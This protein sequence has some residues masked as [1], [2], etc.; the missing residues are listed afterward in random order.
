MSKTFYYFVWGGHGLDHIIKEIENDNSYTDLIIFGPEEHEP[1]MLFSDAE[2][3]MFKRFLTYHNVNLKM[4]L[5]AP[6]NYVLNNR[7]RFKNYKE[8]HSWHTFFANYTVFYN[9]TLQIDP[10]GHND[11]INK[12]FISLNGRAHPWRCMFIDYMYKYKLFDKGYVSWHNTENWGYGYEFKW[13]TPEKLNFDK[14]WDNP[15]DGFY[16]GNRVPIEFKDS[17]FSVISESNLQ[18]IFVTEKTYNPIYHKRPF[19]IFGAPYTH[20]YLKSLG[21]KMFDEVIDYSF[22]SVDNDEKRCNMLMKEVAKIC[23]LDIK[24]TR[25]QLAP[26]VEYNFNNLISL[27][28]NKKLVPKEVKHIIN[29]DNHKMNEHYQAMLNINKREDFL[30]LINKDK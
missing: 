1:G 18:T 21:F 17:L 16:D 3:L 26:I 28:S 10:C 27:V 6:S 15:P 14:N 12:H 11:T 8:L 29:S 9:L 20:Q 24:K 23:S 13:W 25:K 30:N 22:D 7:Y 4:V 2:F 5:G 19:I